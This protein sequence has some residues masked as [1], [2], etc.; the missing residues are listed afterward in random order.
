M[1]IYT[2]YTDRYTHTYSFSFSVN[3]NESLEMKIGNNQQIVH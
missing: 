3:Y 1:C 2:L